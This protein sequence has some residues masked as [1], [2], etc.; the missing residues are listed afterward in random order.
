VRRVA[1]HNAR[2]ALENVGRLA[3]SL[4]PAAL[5]EFGLSPALKDLSNRLEARGGPKVQLDIDLPA[6]TRLPGKL[7]T[8]IFRITQEALT[9]VVKH[10]DANAVRVALARRERSVALTV[11]DDGRGFSQAGGADGGFGLVGIRERVASLNG[12]LDIE[13]NVGAGTRLAIELPLPTAP[14]S[15]S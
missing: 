12:A 14:D 5:D 6:G 13:S 7:E 9:N 1:S 11:E 15:S 3:F 10:A 4:R 2:S 8:A